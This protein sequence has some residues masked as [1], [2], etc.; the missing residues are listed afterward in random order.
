MQTE[1]LFLLMVQYCLFPKILFLL[2]PEENVAFH[3]T[4]KTQ[5]HFSSYNCLY[6]LLCTESEK[7]NVLNSKSY[8]FMHA[9]LQQ[10]MIYIIV[11]LTSESMKLNITEKPGSKLHAS[12]KIT[13]CMD[14]NV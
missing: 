10:M 1:Q 11:L 7:N 6:I 9:T 14:S 5:Y 4:L 2:F 8:E 12:S 13:I 3:R